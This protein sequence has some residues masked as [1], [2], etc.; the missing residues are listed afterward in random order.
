[1]IIGLIRAWKVKMRVSF[2]CPHLDPARTFRMFSSLAVL[3]I[4]NSTCWLNVKDVSKWT[5]RILHVLEV[6]M[7]EPFIDIAVSLVYSILCGV[8][9]MTCDFGAEMDIPRLEAQSVTSPK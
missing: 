2:D 4:R 8:N 6:G 9:K 5:P 3:P 7:T 1:M